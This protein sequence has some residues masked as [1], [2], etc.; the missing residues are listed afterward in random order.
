LPRALHLIRACAAG[1][2]LAALGAIWGAAQAETVT[3]T[4][5]SDGFALTGELRAFDGTYYRILAEYGPVTLSAAQV[6]CS[7][8]GCPGPNETTGFAVT[9]AYGPGAVLLPALLQAYGRA[10]GLPVARTDLDPTH[11]RFDFGTDAPDARRF[12]VTIRLAVT[13]EG[14]ADLAVDEADLVLADRLISDDEAAI[15]RDAG[16]DDLAGPAQEVALAWDALAAVTS[17]RRVRQPVAPDDLLA[18][19]KS[20]APDWQDI[21]FAPGPLR[22][23]GRAHG[24]DIAKLVPGASEVV[25]PVT[26]HHR[27]ADLAAMIREQPSGLGLVA[28]SERGPSQAL[29]LA[30]TCDVIHAPTRANVVLGRYPWTMPVLLY[31]PDRRGPRD[32]EAFLAFLR[33][34]SAEAVIR[35]AGFALPGMDGVARTLP[36]QVFRA[37]GT[38]S[39]PK[40]RRLVRLSERL[41]G[42][43][44]LALA[45][46]PGAARRD[47]R[48]L[49]AAA[50]AR[51]A[52]ATP[53]DGPLVLVAHAASVAQAEA[54]AAQLLVELSRDRTDVP[55]LS[56]EVIALGDALPVACPEDP[57]AVDT[58]RRIDVFR[59]RATDNLRR[60]N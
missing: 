27:G 48:A 15:A 25:A 53:E 20:P 9:A 45:I 14:F 12:P 46:F 31:L 59:L 47:I 49:S 55:D 42:A 36:Q 32:L 44:Q 1:F 56:V 43:E 8:P 3:L 39:E 57:W 54:D 19:W 58:N 41:V 4:S 60:E 5:R 10:L 17:P 40:I 13:G 26:W 28:L 21:G 35:R 7:G 24:E 50:L 22:L 51:L 33:S 18:L 38:A 29:P 34:P 23:H 16:I 11:I 6:W 2:A 52:Q 30:G 37:L